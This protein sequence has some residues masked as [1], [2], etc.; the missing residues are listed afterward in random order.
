MGYVCLIYVPSKETYKYFH[1]MFQ[2]NMMNLLIRFKFV[3]VICYT[4]EMDQTGHIINKST[5]ERK[6]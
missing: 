4:L 1:R 6:S 2:K 3:K 5:K